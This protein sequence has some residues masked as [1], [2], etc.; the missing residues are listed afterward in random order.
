MLGKYDY[1]D[2]RKPEDS[3]YMIFSS[4][5]CNYPQPAYAKWWVTQ[6]RRWGLAEGPQ[7]YAGVTSRVMQTELY[8]EAMAEIGYKHG[9]LD[10]TPWTMMDG[11]AFDPS[12]DLEGY[13]KSFSIK[14][15]KG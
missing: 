1:G 5:N 2:G 13:V 14:N 7:D 4:R 15:L 10:N 8:E 9:A 3:N 11:V 12:A 6:M